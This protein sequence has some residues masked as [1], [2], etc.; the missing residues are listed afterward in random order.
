M[1]NFKNVKDNA[2]Y[3]VV[4][5]IASCHGYL[6]FD[7][8][9]GCINDNLF[10]H[11]HLNILLTNLLSTV[12]SLCVCLQPVNIQIWAGQ[13]STRVCNDMHPTKIFGSDRKSTTL[14]VHKI[15]YFNNFLQL[16]NCRLNRLSSTIYCRSELVFCFY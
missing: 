13:S 5:T 12:S 3:L 4:A 2:W 1:H 10:L 15:F 11:L 16:Y 8:C 7:V 9:K 14:C 6:N